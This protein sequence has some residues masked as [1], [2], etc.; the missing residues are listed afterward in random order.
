MSGAQRLWRRDDARGF[1]VWVSI[2]TVIACAALG[3][4]DVAVVGGMARDAAI[5]C[6]Q[7]CGAGERCDAK[8]GECLACELDAA[9]CLR[10]CEE[11]DDCERDTGTYECSDGRCV[12]DEGDHEEED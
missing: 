5:G 9:E 8:T 11:D 6:E 3:C 7:Q 4:E 2:A 12:Q 10:E 1:W